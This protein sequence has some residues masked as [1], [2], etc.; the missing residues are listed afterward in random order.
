VVT[1]TEVRDLSGREEKRLNE[2]RRE[3]KRREKKRR[4]GEKREIISRD[5]HLTRVILSFDL[6]SFADIN[7]R[8]VSE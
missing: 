7:A 5:K 4:E 3:K 2:M 1:S 6:F 8:F